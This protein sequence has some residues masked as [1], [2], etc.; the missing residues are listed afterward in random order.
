MMVDTKVLTDGL[1]R[2][3]RKLSMSRNN[4]PAFRLQ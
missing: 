3:R 1:T 4:T 2:E